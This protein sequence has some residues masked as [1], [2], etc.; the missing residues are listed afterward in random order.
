[1][2]NMLDI[3]SKIRSN[4]IMKK[5]TNWTLIDWDGNPDLKLKCFRKK[6]GR[7][8]ISVGRGDFLN[9]V[10]S[11]GANSEWSHSGTRWN[12]DN[13][14]F[15]EQ[16]IMDSLDRTWKES[17]KQFHKMEYFMRNSS[18]IILDTPL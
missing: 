10:F 4:P 6:F 16:E 11:F 5:F 17:R 12:Y 8:H 9:I 7:G 13:P 18:K 3:N 1:M 2:R 15:T 14:P